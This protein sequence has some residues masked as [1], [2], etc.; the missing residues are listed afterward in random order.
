VLVPFILGFLIAYLLNPLV[1]RLTARGWRRDRVVFLLY[2]VFV[3]S[4]FYLSL[5]LVPRLLQEIHRTLAEA[6]TYVNTVNIFVEGIN[7]SIHALLKPLL[8]SRAGQFRISFQADQAILHIVDSASANLVNMAHMALW[9]LI[10]PFVSFFALADGKKW[11]NLLFDWTPSRY[12]ESLLGLLAELNARLGGYVRGVLLESMAVGFMTMGGLY[13]LGVQ[14]A[15]LYGVLTGMVNV[16]PFMAPVIGGGL[17]IL[18]AIIQGKSTAVLLGIFFLFVVVR[19]VD[20]FVLVPFIVGNSVQLHP[21]LML[22]AVLVGVEW[23]GFFGLVFAIPAAVVLKVILMLFL[24][25]QRDNMGLRHQGA[26]T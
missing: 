10:V 1:D 13:A 25:S 6:P 2:I 7:V 23:F 8:G 9:V 20:D 14:G 11:I 12:V 17:A 19:L 3:G 18:A 24:K 22:F 4:G 16:V 15:V 26:L 21:L 5:R